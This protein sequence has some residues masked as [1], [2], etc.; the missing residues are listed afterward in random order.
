[1]AQAA[2]PPPA[3][4][5]DEVQLPNLYDVR[6]PVH[7]R[8]LIS[9]RPGDWV[10]SQ[11]YGPSV[12]MLRDQRGRLLEPKIVVRREQ[13]RWNNG[14]PYMETT[15]HLSFPRSVSSPSLAAG[16]MQYTNI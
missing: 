8:S 15:C 13:R 7:D 16:G 12:G 4:D 5:P 6:I 14:V 9:L 2:P 3:E 10:L 11:M 1:M